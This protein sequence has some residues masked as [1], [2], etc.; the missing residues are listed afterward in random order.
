MGHYEEIL[1]A[2]VD[3]D[4]DFILGEEMRVFCTASK[5]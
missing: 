4:I 1:S 3:A 5:G 2:L